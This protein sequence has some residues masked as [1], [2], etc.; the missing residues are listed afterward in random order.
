MYVKSEITE[1]YVEIDQCMCC[2][3]MAPIVGFDPIPV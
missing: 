2:A 1:I 3:E